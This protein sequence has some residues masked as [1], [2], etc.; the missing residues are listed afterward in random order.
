[1]RETTKN[2]LLDFSFRKKSIGIQLLIIGLCGLLLPILPGVLLI[3]F[4]L[5]LLFPK[6][7]EKVLKRN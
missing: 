5:K 2:K 1:M 6:T 7:L 4:G 3:Y